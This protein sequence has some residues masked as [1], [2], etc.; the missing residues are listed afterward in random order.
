[1]QAPRLHRKATTQGH[2]LAYVA[3]YLERAAA[4]ARDLPAVALTDIIEAIDRARANDRIIYV[5]GNGGSAATAAH[6]ANDLGKGEGPML[7][8]PCRIMCLTDNVP[9]LTAW[10]NDFGYEEVFASQLRALC[11]AGDVVVAF[12]GSGNSRNV[13]NGIG[14]AHERGAVTIGFTGFDGGRL[15]GL[16]DHCFLV[17]SHDMQ[18]VEDM[19]LLAAHVVYAALRDLRTPA[20]PRAARAAKPLGVAAP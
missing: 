13:L 6:F 9:V 15:R 4:L 10:A 1:M 14:A 18:H 3:A 16:V 17:P 8:A 19:H 2:E 7:A 20:P 12:S 11:R 5:M